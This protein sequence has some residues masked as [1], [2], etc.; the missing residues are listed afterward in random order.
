[1]SGMEGNPH[2]ESL[3]GYADPRNSLEAMATLALAYEQRTANLI[4]LWG[5]SDDACMALDTASGTGESDWSS[6]AKQI[7][8]RLGLA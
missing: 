5:M 1:M 7:R 8:E 4:A 6:V 2:A 3:T